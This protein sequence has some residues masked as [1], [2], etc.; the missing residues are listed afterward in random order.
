MGF[1]L[2]DP[3]LLEL[4]FNEANFTGV[5]VEQVWREDV[6]E[7]FDDYWAPIEAGIGSIPQ[8]YHALGDSDR[9]SVRDEVRA[10]LT[11]YESSDGKLHMGVE[12]LIGSGRA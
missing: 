7:S 10:R 11:P 6:V 2:A 4:L 9:R 1:S 12:M 5:R 8:A 3:N